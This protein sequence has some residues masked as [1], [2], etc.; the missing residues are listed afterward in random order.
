MGWDEMDRKYGRKVGYWT[1]YV[2]DGETKE[3]ETTAYL[4]AETAPDVYIGNN[5]H[6]EH[7][8]TVR[9]VDERDRYE[10]VAT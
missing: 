5:K 8:V 2:K 3:Y 6:S 9:W 7:P 10:E 4:H 1:T